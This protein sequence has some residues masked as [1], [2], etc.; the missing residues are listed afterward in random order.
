MAQN[1][2]SKDLTISIP[3][4]QDKD[5]GV[6]TCAC[7]AFTRPNTDTIACGC[8]HITNPCIG[9]TINHCTVGTVHCTC[10][11]H[12]PTCFGTNCG[13]VSVQPTGCGCTHV[14]NP[15]LGWTPCGFTPVTCGHGTITITP[16]TCTTSDTPI[17]H[18]EISG[19]TDADTLTALKEKLAN[20]LKE[21]E[22]QQAAIA[23]GKK[24]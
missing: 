22:A 13:I 6:Q 17:Q 18:N 20:A 2:K 10:T 24:G 5:A 19:V 15:C 21:V 9:M 1:F 16:G 11:F 14:T 3:S 4:A 23:K 7:T 12:T 8:T